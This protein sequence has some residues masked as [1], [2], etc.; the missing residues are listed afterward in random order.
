MSD[1]QEHSF[2][3]TLQR[4]REMATTSYR[5]NASNAIRGAYGILHLDTADWNGQKPVVRTR[6]KR[7]TPFRLA[8][9]K[10]NYWVVLT[11]QLT[12]IIQCMTID[13]NEKQCMYVT[14]GSCGYSNGISCW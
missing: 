2:V 5:L 9:S 12:V 4:E 10:T 3:N 11:A 1:T 7:S 14:T 8:Y 6:T 13:N